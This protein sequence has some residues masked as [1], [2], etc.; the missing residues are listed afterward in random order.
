MP[1]RLGRCVLLVWV[2]FVMWLLMVLG[3]VFMVNGLLLISC[4]LQKRNHEL[5]LSLLFFCFFAFL[6]LSLTHF[7][8]LTYFTYLPIPDLSI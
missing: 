2:C 7:T 5:I 4:S 3:E 1:G 6:C 8:N